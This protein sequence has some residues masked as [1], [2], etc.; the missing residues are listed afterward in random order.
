[1]IIK[2][3]LIYLS[4]LNTLKYIKEERYKEQNIC[5]LTTDEADEMMNMIE[6][7]KGNIDDL[8][9]ELNKFMKGKGL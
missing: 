1:M 8:V 9:K 3:F 4:V 2:P 5:R 6:D 7:N